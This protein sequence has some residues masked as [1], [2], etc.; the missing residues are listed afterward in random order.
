MSNK[1]KVC[2]M[3]AIDF[4]HLEK[5]ADY[6]GTAIQVVDCLG[7]YHLM[8]LECNYN[9][10]MVQQFYATVV[11]DSDVNT[12]LTWMSGSHKLKANFQEF[13]ALLGYPFISS[14]LNQGLA[15]TFLAPSMTRNS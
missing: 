2:S 8:K 9:V 3:K 1:K 15:C 11:F 5:K 10:F 12:G 7:L 14:H 13:G 6:F 4:A